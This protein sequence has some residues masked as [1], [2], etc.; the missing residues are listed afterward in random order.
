ML[1]KFARIDGGSVV[2]LFETEQDIR[3]LFHPDLNWVLA[4]FDTQIGDI[5]ADGK[6]SKPIPPIVAPIVPDQV[7]RYQARAALYK[8]GLLDD[9]DGFMALPDT[10]RLL[11]LAW[12]DAQIFK[13][14]SPMVVELGDVLGL[15]SSEIDALFISASF[16]E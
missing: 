13:R 14:D 4:G 10:D 1:K 5:Y 9:V 12:Q 2:E 15:S 16:I 8:S 11:V 3:E 7:T 6:L